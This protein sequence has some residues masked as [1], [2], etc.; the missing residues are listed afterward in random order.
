MPVRQ[1]FPAFSD[2][3]FSPFCEIPYNAHTNLSPNRRG[4]DDD[5]RLVGDQI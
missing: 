3:N 5:I 4:T 1:G 2:E